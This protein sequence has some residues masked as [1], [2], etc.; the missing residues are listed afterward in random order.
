MFLRNWARL[1]SKSTPAELRAESLICLLGK[2]YRAEHPFFGLRR[3]VDFALLDDRIIIEIDGS[4]HNLPVQRRKDLTSTLELE[5]Q[6]WRVVRFSNAEILDVVTGPDHFV[7]LIEERVTHRPTPEELDK[8][9]L[10]LDREFPGIAA[11]P[12]TRR[13]G[14]ARGRVKTKALKSG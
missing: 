11:K 2:R 9:L 1:Y 4:S 6:G 10:D 14:P 3:I 12:R 8:A 13:R 7:R 5:K